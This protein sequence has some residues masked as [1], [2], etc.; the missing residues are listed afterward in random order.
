MPGSRRGNSTWPRDCK[1]RLSR[2][3]AG[4]DDTA[5]RA[6]PLPTVMLSG[7]KH[8]GA[9]VYSVAERAILWLHLQHD[10]LVASPL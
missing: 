5:A 3:P 10:T 8:L 4:F 7:A 2:D 9:V 1:A 6:P